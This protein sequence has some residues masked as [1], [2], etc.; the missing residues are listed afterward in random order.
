MLSHLC[1]GTN[2]FPRAYAFYTALLGELDL[3]EKF[4]DPAKPWAH[5]RPHCHA[6]YL[7]VC[8]HAEE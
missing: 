5:W 4:H 7:C 1:L 3:I 6:S 2:D 8:C